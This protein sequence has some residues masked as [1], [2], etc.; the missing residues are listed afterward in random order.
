MTISASW[1]DLW[2]AA[3]VNH[4]WQSTGVVLVAWLLAL[5]MRSNRAQTHYWIWMVASAKFLIPFSLL[6]D[7][8]EWLRPA[9]AA[10]T[11]SQTFVTVVEQIGQPYRQAQSWAASP[12]ATSHGAGLLP[13]VLMVLWA[14]GSM[15]VAF[16]WWRKWRQIRAVVREATSQEVAADVHVLSSPS[17]LEPGIFGVVRPVLLLPEGILDRL[18]SAQLDAIIAHEMCHVRR[19]DNLTFALHMVVETIFWFH[20]LVWWIGARLVEAREHAC[21]EAVLESGCE[22]EVYAEGILNVCKFYVESPLACASGVSGS[23]LKERITRIM[24]H[25]ATRNLNFYGRLMLSTAGLAIVAVPVTF[26][27]VHASPIGA[28]SATTSSAAQDTEAKKPVFEVAS[29]RPNK[30]GGGASVRFLPS[31]FSASNLNTRNLLMMAYGIRSPDLVEGMPGW[32][33]TDPFDIE[34][35]MDAE[36]FE[37]L[38]KLPPKERSAQRRA[39][40]QSLLVDRYKLKVH[41]ETKEIPIYELVVAKSGFKLKPSTLAGDTDSSMGDGEFIAKSMPLAG[42]AMTLSAEAGRIIEDKTG[43]QGSYDITLQWA[44]DQ[45]RAPDDTRP[46][47]F[48]ALQEELGLKLESAKA[49]AQILIIDRI[50]KPSEN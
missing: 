14:C 40:L 38:Q 37:A 13:I 18:T 15:V 21:D 41:Y 24:A 8:G 26:G 30:A 36:T 16:R 17:L 45:N 22:A 39:M 20:P 32:A 27:V 50:E 7:L 48:T 5:T 4:L 2:T 12:T 25:R 6:I 46:P 44:P 3:L 35:K 33:S 43:I 11:Q 47:L 19:R 9:L 10:P 23:D 42:L 31:G 28:L 49:P 1:N 34:A 29:I